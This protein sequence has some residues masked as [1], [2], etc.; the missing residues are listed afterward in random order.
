MKKNLTLWQF[1]GF[2]LCS[3]AGTLLHFLYEWTDESVL[4][5]PFS[6]VNESTWEHMK[7]LYFPLLI[8][9]LIQSRFF[10]E[11]CNFWCVK[12][13]G[14]TVGLTSIPVLFYTYNGVFGKSPDWVN[15]SIFFLAAAAAFLTEWALFRR[16]NHKCKGE[17]LSITLFGI[18]GLL[19]ILFTF[20]PPHL[21]IFQDP[22]TKTYGI[23]K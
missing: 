13:I 16:K 6:A 4:I 12:Y 21:P 5:A 8:F 19:F 14:F 22:I 11:Y 10:K 7:L 17:N 20:L 1:A 9:A 2:S 15:I 23:P 3:L 18:I